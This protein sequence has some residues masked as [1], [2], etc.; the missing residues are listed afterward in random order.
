MNWN[1]PDW[2]VKVT[3]IMPYAFVILRGLVA[4]SG[5]LSETESNFASGLYATPRNRTE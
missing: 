1:E 2:P 3:K 5:G 4:V